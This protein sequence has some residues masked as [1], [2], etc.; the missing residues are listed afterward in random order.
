MTDWLRKLIDIWDRRQT[1][2]F[3]ELQ[4]IFEEELRIQRKQAM[5]E[6]LNKL[7]ESANPYSTL[8][9]KKVLVIKSDTIKR[10][11]LEIENL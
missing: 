8:K 11:R 10:L 2:G 5:T 9:D 6:I 1:A 3:Y 7:L 4:N